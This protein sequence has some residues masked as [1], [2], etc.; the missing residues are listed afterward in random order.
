MKRGEIWWASLPA[1]R[2]SGPGYRRPVVIVQFDAFNK[3]QLQTI[4]AAVITSNMRLAEAPG[5]VTLLRKQSRLP[6]DSVINVSQLITLDKRYLT[7]RAGKLPA[8]QLAALEDG[9]RL[10]LAL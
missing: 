5:N 10:A 9:L 2:G 4:I 1:P 8:R 3:S 6:K 7:E